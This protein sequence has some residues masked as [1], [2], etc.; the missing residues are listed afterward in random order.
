MNAKQQTFRLD[1]HRKKRKQKKTKT[2]EGV[3]TVQVQTVHSGLAIHPTP[4]V[5]AVGFLLG[6]SLV[7]APSLPLTAPP[8]PAHFAPHLTCSAA[9]PGQ[10]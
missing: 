3:V 2:Y 5:G 10:F 6:R 1:G 9:R 4:A 7:L 8:S